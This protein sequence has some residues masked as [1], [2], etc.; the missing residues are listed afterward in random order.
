ML[1]ARRRS[2]VTGSAA[3]AALAS[4]RQSA[5]AANVKFTTFAFTATGEPTARTMPDRLADIKNVLD[6]G[7]DPTGVADS[8]PA[9]QAAVNWTS[10]TNRG[11]IFFP[12]GRYTLNSSVTYNYNGNLSIR[13]LGEDSAILGSFNGY[14]FDRANTNAGSPNN[15][16]GGR[17]FEKLSFTNSNATGGCVR[18]G[19]TIGGYFRDCGFSGNTCVTTEDSVGVSSQNI[20]FEN[21]N[22]VAGGTSSPTNNLIIG[23]GGVIAACDFRNADTG[24]RLYGS[25]LHICGCRFENMNTAYLCGLDS[26]GNDVGASGFTIT[27]VTTEGNT[28]SFDLAGTCT[29]FLIGPSNSQGHNSSN[30]GYPLG[31]QNSQYGLRIRAGKASAG[32]FDAMSFG[33]QFDVGCVVIGNASSRANL[34]FVGCSAI[35]TGGT[36]VSWSLPTNAYT[37][38]WI[39]CNIEPVWTFSQ[40]PSGGNV[41]EGDEFSIS[42]STTN[43]WGANVTVGSGSDH[44]LVRYNGTNFTVV[45]K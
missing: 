26:G 35:Q 30:S 29:G 34:V 13:F 40:L 17:V 9:I 12:T 2:L 32:V 16:T 33:S 36:G 45:A 4:L 10:G 22:F 19:S 43:T 14:L 1:N 18:I 44:V 37:A 28:T 25:G 7:A 8:Q 15:T 23:G 42:D 20:M 24:V 41:L 39:S 38:Q 5:E 31:V 6:F 11:T 27:S 3:L 21:C